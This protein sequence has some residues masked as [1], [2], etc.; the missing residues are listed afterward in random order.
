MKLIKNNIDK[1]T[2]EGSATLCPEE[3]EDMVS[4]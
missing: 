3:P 1:K 2:G 4:V